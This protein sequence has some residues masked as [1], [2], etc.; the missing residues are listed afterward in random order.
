MPEP[1]EVMVVATGLEASFR[2][3]DPPVAA[4][5]RRLARC[6]HLPHRHVT[7]PEAPD[8]QLGHLRDGQGGWL[9]SLP[10]D[11]GQAL[12][13][14]RTW[15]EALGAWQQPTLVLIEG[16][17]LASGAAAS[18]T[19]LLRQWRVPMLGLLQWGGA[20]RAHQRRR[21]GLPWLGRLE[22]VPSE[23]EDS[24][25]ALAQLL[26]GRWRLLDLPGRLEP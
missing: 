17:Q 7:D 19:A 11:P 10:L 26:L 3:P 12:G 4:A 8:R 5:A 22:D 25:G 13:D 16:P 15:A 14:G 21:D 20:W 9:A 1:L 24:A 6:L 18:T 2:V 23:G